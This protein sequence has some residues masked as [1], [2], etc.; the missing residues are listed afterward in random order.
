M[1]DS[2]TVYKMDYFVGCA[3]PLLLRL[4][5]L[6][7][8]HA[9]A[10]LSRCTGCGLL[11]P[12]SSTAL[13]WPASL[14][15]VHVSGV[16]TP[17]HVESS[18]AGSELMSPALGADFFY[19][20]EPPRKSQ[21]FQINIH[22]PLDPAISFLGSDPGEKFKCVLESLYSDVLSNNF[23]C[24]SQKLAVIRMWVNEWANCRSHPLM[25]IAGNTKSELLIPRT[26][27]L[28]AKTAA[29]S[30]CSACAKLVAPTSLSPD[31]GSALRR[32]HPL[33]P[34]SVLLYSVSWFKIC[35]G[36]F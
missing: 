27:W 36:H 1:E 34:K 15:V 8:W 19:H 20:W 23:I 35:N 12:Q 31:L 29:R 7:P 28:D 24:D 30:A 5:F 2:L 4:G 32:D 18:Q 11:L 6:Q 22:L 21:Q 25:G 13:V 33:K 16:T 14:A 3:R 26:A 10:T 17:W 9:A